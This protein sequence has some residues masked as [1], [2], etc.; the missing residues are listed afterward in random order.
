MVE[1]VEEEVEE[2]N[3]VEEEE[4]EE[5]VDGEEEVYRGRGRGGIGER[6]GGRDGIRC[7]EK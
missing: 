7:G 1:E 2:E 6:G 5:E 3:E 4:M